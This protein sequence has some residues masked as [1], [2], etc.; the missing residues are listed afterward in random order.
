MNVR[1]CFSPTL[2]VVASLLVASEVWAEDGLPPARS[3]N[4]VVFLS[5]DQGSGDFSIAGNRDLQTP[6]IDSLAQQG[7]LIEQFFVCPVCSPTRAEFLTGRYHPRGGVFST[8]TGGERLDLDETTIAQLF[9]QAGYATG[10]FGKWHNGMQ[11]PYHPNARGFDTFYGFCSG[12]WGH[13]FS[14]ML[15]R[16]NEIV[17]GQ[18]L[19]GMNHSAPRKVMGI[20]TMTQPATFIRRNRD[21][22]MNTSKAPR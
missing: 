4:V 22:T 14:P 15:E 13:Y 20:P 9:Q 12:H 16:N 17:T 11:P 5:D 1:R 2:L 19:I 3:P 21:S 8:S 6:H 10:A 18:G 7:A